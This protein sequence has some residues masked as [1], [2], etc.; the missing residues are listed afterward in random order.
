[1]PRTSPSTAPASTSCGR[2][3]TGRAAVGAHQT[4][5][6]EPSV[7]PLAAE[8]HG[9]GDEH[10]D[11]H[12]QHDEDDQDQQDQYRIGAF[13]DRVRVPEPVDAGD[14]PAGDALGREALGA[15]VVGEFG[16]ADQPALA[17]RA[18]DLLR[19]PL[20]Q[21][22]AATG[23]QQLL[24]R[25]ETTISPTAGNFWTPGGRE[26]S[27]PRA[28]APVRGCSCPGRSFR[29][30]PPAACRPPSGDLVAVRDVRTGV[31]ALVPHRQCARQRGGQQQQ[32]HAEAHADGGQQCPEPSFASA[33]EGEPNPHGEVSPPLPERHTTR[34][35]SRDFPSRTTIS[36]SE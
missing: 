16:G 20:S 32:R 35:M 7:A 10:G 18:D 33:R 9:G 1:M 22:R 26:P 5:G 15:P 31:L 34:S 24:Q 23:L 11:R 27:A 25:G 29:W 21:E 4:Q 2:D 17:D 13:R 6:G 36:R 12:Q 28:P 3:P 14:P 19:Q 30:P 8:A